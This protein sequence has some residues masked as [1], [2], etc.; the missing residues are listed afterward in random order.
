MVRLE[1]YNK[2]ESHAVN[3][4]DNIKILMSNIYDAREDGNEKGEYPDYKKVKESMIKM[5]IFL[6]QTKGKK[7]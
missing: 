5:D 1:R 2:L 3:L 7:L 6:R 4:L